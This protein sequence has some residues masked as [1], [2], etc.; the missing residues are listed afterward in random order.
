MKVTNTT[1]MTM[2]RLRRIPELASDTINANRNTSP[3]TFSTAV[4]SGLKGTN[5]TEMTM[6]RFRRIP[7]SVSETINANRTTSPLTF[8]TA[9]VSGLWC[10]LV[11]SH[12]LVHRARFGL[13]QVQRRVDA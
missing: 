4:V 7:E 3:L 1:E 9:I 13:L 5:T 11:D 12:L 10:L 2:E 8:S 6:E